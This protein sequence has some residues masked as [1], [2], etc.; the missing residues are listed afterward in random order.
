MC[1]LEKW[2]RWTY[3]QNR[4]IDTGVESK[5]GFQK[6]DGVGWIERLGLTYTQYW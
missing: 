6:W 1:N 2:Y 5:H 3:L 4:N